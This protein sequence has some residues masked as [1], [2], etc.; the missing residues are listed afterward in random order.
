MRITDYRGSKTVRVFADEDEE[1]STLTS[2]VVGLLADGHRNR[3]KRRWRTSLTV[4]A[5]S[6]G[7]YYT[8]TPPA[9][10]DGTVTDTS[11]GAL[12]ADDQAAIAAEGAKIFKLSGTDRRGADPVPVM[13]HAR[14]VRTVTTPGGT[15]VHYYRLV[16]IDGGADTRG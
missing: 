10:D 7:M 12:D 16:D 2:G 13:D 4:T 8:A 1:D 11:V 3:W 6:V 9:T 14:I 5:T 15:P